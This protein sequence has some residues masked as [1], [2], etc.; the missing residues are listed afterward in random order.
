[1]L[2][3]PD[4]PLLER[5]GKYGMVR[6]EEG[7]GDDGPG[8]IPANFLLIDE[9]AHELDDGERRV[10]IVELD[11]DVCEKLVNNGGIGIKDYT[12]SQETA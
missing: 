12:N 1:M 7:L 5:L 4:G 3:E 6:V 8:I 10:S 11:G 2:H 9:D